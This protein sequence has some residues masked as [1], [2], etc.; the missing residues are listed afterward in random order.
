MTRTMMT[1]KFSD[2]RKFRDWANENE[3][4]IEIVS[5]HYCKVCEKYHV[6]YWEK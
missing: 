3:A 1:S 5:M 4:R 2:E 6:Q